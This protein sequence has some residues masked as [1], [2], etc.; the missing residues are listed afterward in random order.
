[1]EKAYL[2]HCRD[3]DSNQQRSSYMVVSNAETVIRKLEFLTGILGGVTSFHMSIKKTILTV[4]RKPTMFWT[5]KGMDLGIWPINLFHSPQ[6]PQFC[7]QPRQPECLSGWK[8]PVLLVK[9]N[10]ETC[11]SPSVVRYSICY[12]NNYLYQEKRKIL[13]IIRSCR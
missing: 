9:S 13:W 6:I 8:S 2:P 3:W 12:G 7:Q 1:M 10:H 5:F 4:P 11:Y